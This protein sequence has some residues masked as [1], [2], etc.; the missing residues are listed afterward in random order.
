M[1][2]ARSLWIPLSFIAVALPAGAE[3]PY[4]PPA[5]D[6]WATRAPQ[7]LG[8]DAEKLA[9][10]VKF[11]QA[12][13]VNWPVDVRAQIEKDTAQEPYPEII[14]PVK[15]RGGRTASSCGTATS[16]RNGATR[17]AWT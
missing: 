3:P 8:F 17:N 13:E 6:G 10:A 12:N 4:F 2:L 16:S 11:A 7:A 15:P 5:G 9:A 1:G 14:G